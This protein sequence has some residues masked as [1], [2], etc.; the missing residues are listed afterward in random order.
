MRKKL[1][2]LKVPK[3]TCWGK[4]RIHKEDRL[5]MVKYSGD[6]P[7][8]KCE[9]LPL[10]QIDSTFSSTCPGPNFWYLA[11]LFFGL[12]T[13]LIRRFVEHKQ[14]HM[15]IHIFALASMNVG[16]YQTHSGSHTEYNTFCETVT[17]QYY[18]TE[19]YCLSV[20]L[21][22]QMGYAIIFLQLKKFTCSAYFAFASSVAFLS[23]IVGSAL[24]FYFQLLHSL[25][26][27]PEAE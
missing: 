24:S 23:D 15:H 27:F 11:H 13:L 21:S 4:D 17:N 22:C 9:R 1:H 16:T 12:I 10:S 18:K 8:T 2:K 14:I 25:V 20:S 5:I 19:D 7:K 26:P 3:S 6:C